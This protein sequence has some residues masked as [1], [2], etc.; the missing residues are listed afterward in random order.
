MVHTLFVLEGYSEDISKF[1]ELMNNR[2]YKNFRARS[3]M[4][5]VRFFCP[6]VN[7]VGYMDFLG[8]LKSFT[9]FN[10]MNINKNE[11]PGLKDKMR[12]FLKIFRKVFKQIKPIEQDLIDAKSSNLAAEERKKGRHYRICCYP[13]G[14]V[15]D[16]RYEDGTE[17]V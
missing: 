1:T 2:N 5:E 13:I 3:R 10:K 6:S 16:A 12:L 7:E 15:L 8:D 17:I 14:K 11:G 9:N 4:R